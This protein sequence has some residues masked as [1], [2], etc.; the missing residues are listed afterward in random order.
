MS[1]SKVIKIKPGESVTIVCDE[2]EAVQTTPTEDCT[3]ETQSPNSGGEV[4]P[5]HIIVRIVN[6]VRLCQNPKLL[7]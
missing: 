7:N 5:K 4:N 2:K 3:I 6:K 1:E